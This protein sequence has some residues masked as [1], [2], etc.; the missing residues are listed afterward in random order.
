MLQKL[1]LVSRLRGLRLRSATSYDLAPEKARG[2][3]ANMSSNTR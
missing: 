3:S 1:H 2:G